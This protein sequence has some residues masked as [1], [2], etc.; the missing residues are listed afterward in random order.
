MVIVNLSY[1]SGN[2]DLTLKVLFDWLLDDPMVVITKVGEEELPSL[3]I[4]NI[5]VG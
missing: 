2:L 1:I 5:E 4:K 3:L